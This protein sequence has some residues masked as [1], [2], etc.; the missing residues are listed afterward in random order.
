MSASEKYIDCSTFEEEYFENKLGALEIRFENVDT[1]RGGGVL[2]VENHLGATEIYVPS[3]W[4]VKCNVENSLGSVEVNGEGSE[5][6]NAP[7]ITITGENHL[8]AVEINIA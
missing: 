3:S 4:N 5:D 7:T 6:E 1:Y 2:H 8:G